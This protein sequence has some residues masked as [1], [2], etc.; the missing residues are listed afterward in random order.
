MSKRY[1]PA[2]VID[3]LLKNLEADLIAA[4]DAEIRDALVDFDFGAAAVEVRTLL[5]AACHGETLGG[6]P[7]AQPTWFRT[8]LARH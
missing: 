3:R 8:S 1:E 7:L 5:V 2:L 6:E 4:T